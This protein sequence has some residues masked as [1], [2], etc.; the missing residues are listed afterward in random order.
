M[1][2][3]SR[4]S[5]ASFD[6]AFDPIEPQRQF[7]FLDSSTNIR[8]KRPT[9]VPST[10]NN[11]PDLNVLNGSHDEPLNEANDQYLSFDHF[12]QPSFAEQ[13][14]WQERPSKGAEEQVGVTE[15]DWHRLW[16]QRSYIA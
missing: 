7:R 2:D 10:V 8:S 13:G 9:L 3:S 11:N 12:D 14:M 5:L 6:W 4:L 1:A 15:E 16:G